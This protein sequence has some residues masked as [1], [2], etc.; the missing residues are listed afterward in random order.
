MTILIKVNLCSF[1]DQFGAVLY[2]PKRVLLVLNHA[3]TELHFHNPYLT[4]A[5]SRLYHSGE[6]S[7]LRGIRLFCLPMSH[8]REARLICVKLVKLMVS[9]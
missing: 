4:N 6:Y 3:G 7:V 8:K 2:T 1:E 9:S 5:F